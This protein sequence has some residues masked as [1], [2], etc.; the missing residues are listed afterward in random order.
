VTRKTRCRD[1][2]CL[3]ATQPSFPLDVKIL[4]GRLRNRCASAFPVIPVL[5]PLFLPSQLDSS[6]TLTRG[7]AHHHD[8][9]PHG[10]ERDIES[11]GEA[12]HFARS[13]DWL[14]DVVVGCTHKPPSLLAADHPDGGILCRMDSLLYVLIGADVR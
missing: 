13:Q 10:G 2:R 6:N 4:D 8:A 1:Q 11:V 5:L 14:L 9:S 3:Q 7:P 12:A